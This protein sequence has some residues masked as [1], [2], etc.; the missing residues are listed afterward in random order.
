MK[1]TEMIR[2]TSI[3]S[4][5]L[6]A[7]LLVVFSGCVKEPGLDGTGGG[8]DNSSVFNFSTN[9]TYTLNVKYTVPEGYKVYFEV[10]SSNPFITDEAGQ[11]VKN[12]ALEPID[13]GYTDAS[14]RY[15]HSIH[16]PAYVETL[17]I[18]TPNA[19]VPELMTCRVE[20]GTLTQAA[21]PERAASVGTK[22]SSGNAVKMNSGKYTYSIPTKILGEWENYVQGYYLMPNNPSSELQ[23]DFSTRSKQA[24]LWGRPLYMAYVDKL[25]FDDAPASTESAKT[26]SADI[27][28]T[29]NTVL[30][31]NNNVDPEILKNGD[32]HVTK[33]A[34]IS[35]Y[36][37]DERGA[38]FNTLAYYCYPTGQA[39]TSASQIKTQVIALPNAKIIRSHLEAY[40]NAY[41]YGALCQGE[42]VKLKYVDENG[43]MHDKFPAGVSI[44]WVLYANGFSAKPMDYSVG[45]GAMTIYSNPVL[46]K[47]GET[48]GTVFRHGDFV[49]TSF[50][51][52]P[53]IPSKNDYDDLIFHV[54]ATPSDAITP[55]IPDKDPEGPKDIEVT[56]R[57][58]LSFEDNWPYWGD[59][60]MNDVV[61]KYVSTVKY[62]SNN[63][64]VASDDKFTLLWSG[65]AYNNSF[66]YE[67][68]NIAAGSPAIVFSD[69]AAKGSYRDTQNP[70]IIRVAS[71]ILDLL[72]GDGKKTYSIKY[73]YTRPIGKSTFVAPPYSPFITVRGDASHE[74]HL[75][76]MA[77]TS[78]MNTGLLGIGKDH[79][80][81]EK[82]IYYIT[83]DESNQQMP[84][85]IDLVFDSD[86]A[87][88][89][90]VIPEET[91]RIDVFYPNFLKWIKSEGK[92]NQ[93]WYL[94]PK[95]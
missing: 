67:N 10:Y 57:G 79:S 23:P 60:D 35:L 83:Y 25:S 53:S 56:R 2:R 86:K 74:V 40:N 85:A 16:L 58:I 51:D 43:T 38:Y 87:M 26:I 93:D 75:T 52:S 65:A 66:A 78:Y 45:T 47:N 76:N 5:V 4:I 29:I 7:L 55:G 92:D 69:E 77:P 68:P 15:S 89:G 37:L 82:G 20:N 95:K 70:N 64:V 50:E 91:K 71:G 42:G 6:G 13:K 1:K 49:I 27:W 44:G 61:V 28:K 14:G 80:K 21:L 12:D 54:G 84:F 24:R 19:G 41:D 34:E 72:K 94:H 73:D 81:P 18:Y 62:N 9:A 31:G 90:Y 8:D 17:Y 63:E 30:P 32:I 33:E 39:P 3:G 22:A 88:D 59:F 48:F 46:N 36:L 11:Q